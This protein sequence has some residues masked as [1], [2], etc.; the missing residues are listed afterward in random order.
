M[1]IKNIGCFHHETLRKK[2]LR[3]IIYRPEQHKLNSTNALTKLKVIWLFLVLLKTDLKRKYIRE[4]DGDAVIVAPTLI[5]MG[6]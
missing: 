1:K 6:L 5:F 3:R 2:K 4:S